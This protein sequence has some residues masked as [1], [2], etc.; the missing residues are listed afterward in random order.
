MEMITL[1]VI[2]FF[3]GILSGLAVGGGTLLVP[4]LILLLDVPQHQAQAL[5][6]TTFLPMSAVALATHFKNG[7]VRPKLA[8]LLALG[9]IT[10]A[11]GGALLANY[12][13]GAL[14]RKIFGFFLVGMGGY[15]LISRPKKK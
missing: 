4:A 1:S 10:G 15:E 14:L 6:L 5:A 3:S 9:A 7:N 11:I 12:L 13:P 8:F 2:G